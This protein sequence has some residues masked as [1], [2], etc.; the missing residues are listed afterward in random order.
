[1]NTRAAEVVLAEI[2]AD[3]TRFPSTANLASWAGVCPGSTTLNGR[4][5]ELVASIASRWCSAGRSSVVRTVDP[6]PCDLL[7]GASGSACTCSRAQHPVAEDH[8]PKLVCPSLVKLR[9]SRESNQSWPDAADRPC[10][11]TSP[12]TMDFS[13]PEDARSSGRRE[14]PTARTET[15]LAI[16]IQR[17]DRARQGALNPCH[18]GDVHR[19]HRDTHW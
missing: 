1:M 11:A 12:A 17:R 10:G 14:P 6:A 16:R 19:G 3:I 2:G 13:L 15:D 18:S 5:G 4:P 7:P 9:A 8:H